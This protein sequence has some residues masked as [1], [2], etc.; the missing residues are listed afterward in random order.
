[1]APAR[2]P[3]HL[4]W[5]KWEAYFTWISGFALLAVVYYSRADLFLIDRNV[6]DV[7]ASI[8]IL[9]SIASLGVGWAGLR[10][11]VPLAAR[12]RTTPR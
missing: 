12:P 8:G 7:S 4:T 2:L 1:M 6:L 11:L 5:F 9:I 3:E 10:P